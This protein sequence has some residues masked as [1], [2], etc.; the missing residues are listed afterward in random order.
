VVF[1]DFNGK[2]IFTHIDGQ[3][4]MHTWVTD[5][6]SAGTHEIPG[7]PGYLSSFKSVGPFLYMHAW[8]EG[9]GSEL[10]VWDGSDS[11]PSMVADIAPGADS[12][13]PE[14]LFAWGKKLYFS[15]S[16]G[17]AAGAGHGSELWGLEVPFQQ[18]WM[19]IMRK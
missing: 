9:A 1:Y 2:G 7:S 19:P 8:S 6:T 11:P 15:A 10:W 5:G 17:T 13:N 12:A 16:D 4:R 14:N 3:H 18:I